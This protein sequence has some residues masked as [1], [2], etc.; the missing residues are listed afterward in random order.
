MQTLWQ[1][2]RYGLRLLRKAPGFATLA[3]VTLAL[4]IGANTPTFSI[5]N[6]VLLEPLPLHDPSRKPQAALGQTLD[7]ARAPKARSR[8]SQALAQRNAGQL[9]ALATP[10]PQASPPPPAMAGGDEQSTG[11]SVGQR[12]NGTTTTVT[13]TRGGGTF[14]KTAHGSLLISNDFDYHSSPDGKAWAVAGRTW[15]DANLP[16][17]LSATRRAEIERAHRMAKGPFL[18]FTDG[19]R[20]YFV[21]D[22][23]AVSRIEGM[24][25]AMSDLA[26][27]E[28]ELGQE[29]GELGQEQSAVSGEQSQR[30]ADALARVQA[31]LKA[32]EDRWTPQ[33]RAKI[34]KKLKEAE[35]LLA[36]VQ[37]RLKGEKGP[38]GGAKASE[39]GE[40]QGRLGEAQGLLGEAEGQLAK[41]IDREVQRAIQEALANGKAR[42]VR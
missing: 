14:I 21:T 3:V 41:E 17:G 22:P 19:G 34:Q 15:S 16:S 29:Q 24:C 10:A 42:L 1:E 35:K 9:L 39:L 11:A 31:E 28:G 20:S 6:A 5:V 27:E 32:G 13:T 25:Q 33:S 2:V 37:E 40:V 18:W 23:A 4:G 8:A 26:R 30:D 36:E 12:S 7:A 38:K